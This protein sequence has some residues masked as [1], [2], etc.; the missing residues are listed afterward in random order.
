MERGKRGLPWP[1]WDWMSS[2]LTAVALNLCANPQ[3]PMMNNIFKRCEESLL[4]K[5]GDV[6]TELMSCHMLS[7]AQQ[8]HVWTV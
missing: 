7:A 5:G 8:Q 2:L 1:S 4:V 6:G 3:A